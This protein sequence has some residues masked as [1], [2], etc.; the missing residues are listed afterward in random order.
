M[1][2]F[3]KIDMKALG[4]DT[5]LAGAV[6]GKAVFVKVIAETA[7]EPTEPTALI[8]DFDDVQIATASF[9]RETVF[10][11]KTYMRARQSAFYPVV[12]NL[13]AEIRDELAVLTEALNDAI[14]S[15]EISSSGVLSNVQLFGKL[16]PK[17]QITFDYIVENRVADANT[18][19]EQLGDTDK[20]K[21]TNAWNNRLAS[22]VARGVIKEFS[23]GRAKFYKPIL[24]EAV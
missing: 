19:K 23:R 17:Q 13:N 11:A 8:M 1:V 6:T 9:L 15:C 10:A 14:I 5:V 4:N 18:L 7:I 20:A 22:L 24:D 12:A 3:M 21:N 2:S 16:D